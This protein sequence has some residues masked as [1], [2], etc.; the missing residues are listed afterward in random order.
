MM[1]T[2]AYRR[3][4][5]ILAIASCGPGNVPQDYAPAALRQ[6]GIHE[7]PVY[8]ARDLMPSRGVTMVLAHPRL[9]QPAIRRAGETLDVSW[10]A[11]S[12]QPAQIT[13]AQQGVASGG[14]CDADGICHLSVT[15]PELPAGLYALCVETECSPGAVA[16][17]QQYSDPVTVIHFSDTHVGDGASQDVFARVV[18]AINATP[19]DFAIFTGDAADTGKADQRAGFLHELTRLQ[20]PVYVVTGNHDYDAVGI[21]GHLLDIGPELDFAA[22][23]GALRLIGIS[24][25]QDMDDGN[26]NSTISESDGPD[27]SQL[28]WLGEIIAD[29]PSIVF[30]H[31]PIYNGLFATIGPQ[32]RDALKTLVTRDNVLA[33]LTGHTHISAVFDADGNSRGLSLDSDSDVPIDRWPLHYGAAR[34]TRG[35]GGFAI[36]HFGPAHLDYRWV[37][38]P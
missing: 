37:A 34:V 1:K 19:A 20:L 21:D 15:V 35:T 27:E 29:A 5:L 25:G 17:V 13:I 38:L 36:L 23:Y 9:G 31:H 10:I 30:F 2:V 11:A 12:P 4:G 3:V 26:H 24:S 18:D 6:L 22:Q 7:A 33:V 32:S 8:V 14:T 16:V 28:N